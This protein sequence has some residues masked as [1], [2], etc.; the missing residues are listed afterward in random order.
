VSFDPEAILAFWFG[1]AASDPA[2]ASA[3]ETRWFGAS[4]EV[5]AQIR[6]RFA[7]AVEAAAQGEL[8]GWLDA[9]RSALALV[10][11]LDQFPRNLWRGTARAFAHDAK[12]RPVAQEALA[13]GHLRRLAPV[14][15][16]F[17]LLPLQHSEDLEH[18]QESVRQSR[19]IAEAAPAAWRPLL[20]HYLRFAEQHLELIER[21]GRFPHRNRALGRD[22]SPEE[23]AYLRSGGAS[24]GQGAQPDGEAPA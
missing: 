5:D 14:E 16:A 9:P 23:E 2:Q 24:F 13:R 10:L 1:E 17:L 4:A 11:L 15:Q 21:F 12:A 6:E 8:D 20:T 19:E 18:Q 7:S 22:P 3:R